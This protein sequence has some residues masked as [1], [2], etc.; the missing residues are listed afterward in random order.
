MSVAP[1]VK[2]WMLWV[3]Y[4]M[5]KTDALRDLATDLTELVV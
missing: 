3:A 1:S 5:T 2:K 4:K